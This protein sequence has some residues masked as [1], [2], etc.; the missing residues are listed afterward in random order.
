MNVRTRFAPSPTGHLHLGNVRTAVFNW[1]F[2]RHHDGVFVLRVE[3]T[4]VE[5]NVP[6][7]EA[8]LMEDLRWLGLDWDEGP[9]VDGPFGPYRQSERGGIYEEHL[10]RLLDSRRAYPCFCAQDEARG[11][12]R[13][14]PGTCRG[15]DEDEASRRIAAGEP[16]VVRIAGPERGRVTIHDRVRGRIDFPAEDLDDFV[17]RRRDGRVTYNFAVVVDDVTMEISH[18]IRGA[19]HL[20]NT[21]KQAL[22]FDAFEVP[23]PTFVHLP[24]VLAPDG[25][26]LSKRKGAPGVGELRRRG[27]LPEAVVNYLSLLGWSHPE[28][29]EVLSVAELVADIDLDRIRASEMAYD[30]AKL[31]WVAGQHFAALPAETVLE[32][33]RSRLDRGRFPLPEAGLPA[34]VD[35]LRSRLAA[36]GDF[37]THLPLLYPETELWGR[38]REAVGGDP[39]ARGVLEAALVELEGLPR[40][41]SEDI[42]A[43]FKRA[44]EARGVRGR[45][46]FHPLRMA[47]FGAESGPDLGALSEAVGRAEVMDRLRA[48]LSGGQAGAPR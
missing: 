14:Y 6:G 40:W 1:L 9:D 17:L 24:N 34:A 2:A 45:E 37:E 21:P 32:G 28:E 38:A 11:A 27:M 5:R 33:V 23:R 22:L 35:A 46:L 16:H 44:G 29:K 41:S 10:G 47:L 36:F 25:G 19:G 43:G 26:K 12:D 31:E 7:A 42:K 4:D 8:A 18:V 13:R 30:P 48:T 15:L 20:S 3:D 39:S